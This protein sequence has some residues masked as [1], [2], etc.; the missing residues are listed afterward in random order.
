ML[1]RFS[2]K[3]PRPEK[4]A[5]VIRYGAYGDVLQT[6]SILPGL[7]K[8]GYH[9]TFICTPRG[10]DVIRNDPHIDKIILQNEDIVPNQLLLDY[11]NYLKSKY[12]KVINMCE[13]VEGIVLPTSHRVHFHWS[14]EAR[15][16]MCNRNYVELQHKIA[17]V[18]YEG[19]EVRFYETQEE[20]DWF[21]D[22]RLKL[23][24]PL[25]SWVLAGSG[26][27]KIWP[28]IDSV[29]SRILSNTDATVVLLGGPK[30]EVLQ[31]EWNSPRVIRTAGRFSIRQGMAFAKYSDIVIGPETGIMSAVSIEE[32]VKIVLLSHSTEENLTRDWVNTISLHADV[33][34]YPCHRLHLDGWKYCNRHP[35]GTAMCQM[36]LSPDVV[37]EAVFNSLEPMRKVA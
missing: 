17:Q 21:K 5:A 31:G 30:E 1:N 27:H 10:V 35:E 11:F 23:S 20:R 19:P 12:T 9:I 8:E 32:N 34:C 25:I 7:K 2:W 37:Y 16:M 26:V 29:I 18:P 6:A 4:T 15:H 33:D 13:T 28:H 22:L 24:G 36:M 3:D 14:K